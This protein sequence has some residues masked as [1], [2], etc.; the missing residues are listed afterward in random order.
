MLVFII[1]AFSALTLL[2]G[3]Q[4]GYPACKNWVM[5]CWRGYLSGAR[6]SLAYG[7]AGATVSCFVKIQIDLT[8][9]V[10]AY[11][12]SPGKRAIKCVCVCVC[13]CVCACVRAC[14]CAC[15]LVFIMVSRHSPTVCECPW[16][17]IVIQ[18]MNV[19]E[20]KAEL[21]WACGIQCWL[22]QCV[23][24]ELEGNTKG[25]PGIDK[26]EWYWRGYHVLVALVLEWVTDEN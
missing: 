11:P 24:V 2:V 4:E 18:V 15:V 6:C 8:F 12:G 17:A 3:R 7:T 19:W 25:L 13:V 23:T 5:G 16:A 1:I 26:M 14:V 21:V 22:D 20:Q 9:L 10:P